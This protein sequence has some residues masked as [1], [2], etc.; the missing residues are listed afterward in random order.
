MYRLQKHCPLRCEALRLHT[1]S[2][3]RPWE[4]YYD[5]DGILCVYLPT[6]ISNKSTMSS[7][8]NLPEAL[9]VLRSMPL[10]AFRLGAAIAQLLLHIPE[11]VW[12]HLDHPIDFHNPV[13]N[14]V[15]FPAFA[16]AIAQLVVKIRRMHSTHN[17]LLDWHTSDYK[18]RRRQ[19]HYVR[20]LN[21][22][23]EAAYKYCVLEAFEDR[24]L[25]WS[26]KETQWFNQGMIV[27]LSEMDW[28][29]M[30]E[31]NVLIEAKD[32]DWVKW[33]QEQCSELEMIYGTNLYREGSVVEDDKRKEAPRRRVSRIRRILH[34]S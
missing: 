4:F 5:Q 32:G 17:A 20:G 11:L 26:E 25:S 30:P 18:E 28:R 19:L 31:S 12:E 2:V 6:T 3:Q 29:I 27:S 10:S 34:L 23:V 7:D 14:K 15:G 1:V 13:S 22:T 24:F 8:C 21:A 16:D 33:L 9:E